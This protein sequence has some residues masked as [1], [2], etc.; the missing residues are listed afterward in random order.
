M[1][2]KITL[3][4]AS[5]FILTLTA[6]DKS[7]YKKTKS[8]L[9]YKL[10]SGGSKDS[11]ARVGNVVK[12][13]FARKYN[14]SLIFTSFDKMPNFIPLQSDPGLAY[15]PVE[16]LFLARKGDSIV[17]VEAVDSLLKKGK[18]NQLPPTAKKGDRITTYIKILEV[19]KNDSLAM[20]DYQA[21]VAK[22]KP[23]Q[24]KEAQEMQAKADAQRIEQGKADWEELKKSGE[25]EKG[26]KAMQSYLGSKKITAQKT[27]DGTFVV[28]KEKGTGEPVV[29]GKFISVKYTGRILETDS[30][31][32]S[33]VY[34]FK[35]GTY[36]VIHGWDDGLKLFNKGG[37]G[38][39]YIPGYLAYAKNPGPGNKPFQA[40]I[41]D[42]E[43]TNVSDTQE[44]QQT[45]Q[46]PNQ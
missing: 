26:I 45:P 10:I 2:S 19:Y 11:V 12:I 5:A 13:H 43:V 8:G 21:E 35:L 44:P 39:L 46:Q 7:S 33:S 18:S 3:I 38:T 9:V 25:M 37:K 29:D 42:V 14:D 31:F 24:E 41:F 22:D 36:S 30:V 23:R 16:I 1:K 32:Q 40:L 34:T 4:I 27:D 28:V 6:C 20:S 15:S 17:T